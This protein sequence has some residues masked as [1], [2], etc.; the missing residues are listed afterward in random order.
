[1]SLD[2][3]DFGATALLVMDHQALLVDGYAPD[4]AGHLA[5][6]AK[7][8]SAA[9]AAGLPVIYVCV[10]FRPG[11]PEVSDANQMFRAVRDGGRFRAGDPSTEIP[12]AIRPGEGDLVLTKH[13]VSAFEGTDLEM[14]LRARR[15]DTLVLFGIAT[16]GVVLSTVR[17]A[18]DRDYRLMVVSDLCLDNDPEV[19]RCLVDKILPRQ[20]TMISSDEFLAKLSA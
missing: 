20:A 10:G 3:N 17:Q 2:G 9:R 8:I 16:S 11:Y 4:P 19:H 13:R 12:E 15:I 14:L 1:M 18:A 5:S 7:V 6:V